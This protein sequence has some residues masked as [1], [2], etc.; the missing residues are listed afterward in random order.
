MSLLFF[1]KLLD[2]AG[3]ADLPRRSRPKNPFSEN[4]PERERQTGAIFS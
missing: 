4:L 2:E 1:I 3:A